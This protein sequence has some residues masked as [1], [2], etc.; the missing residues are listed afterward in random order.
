MHHDIQTI[1]DNYG[2][3]LKTNRNGTSFF[4]VVLFL[5][6]KLHYTDIENFKN[7]DDAERYIAKKEI[8]RTMDSLLGA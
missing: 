7:F 3:I 8:E 5:D 4:S 1:T 2:I 6:K